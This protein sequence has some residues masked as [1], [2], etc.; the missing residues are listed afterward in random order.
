MIP[1][2]GSVG[3]RVVLNVPEN[4]ILNGRR[5]VIKEIRDWGVFVATDAAATGEFRALWSEIFYEDQSKIETVIEEKITLTESYSVSQRNGET[6]GTLT[7]NS[8]SSISSAKKSRSEGYTGDS[9]DI[10]GSFKTRRTGSC[11]TCEDCGTNG[12]CS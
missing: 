11:W 2:R 1:N 4:H 12:G 9:C 3:D 7:T 6:N 8:S 5:G 10:C